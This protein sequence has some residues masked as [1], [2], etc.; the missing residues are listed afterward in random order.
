M[1]EL[2]IWTFLTAYSL[3]PEK[4]KLHDEEKK[5]LTFEHFGFFFEVWG[6]FAYNCFVC[7][8]ISLWEPLHTLIHL[9]LPSSWVSLWSC[10]FRNNSSV[11][12][13]KQNKEKAA[14]FLSILLLCCTM[15]CHERMK[16]RQTRKWQYRWQN[17]FSLYFWGENTAESLIIIGRM[18]DLLKTLLSTQD[19]PLPVCYIFCTVEVWTKL[20]RPII[21]KVW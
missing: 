21:A 1:E 18:S 5:S 12:C 10:N 11:S 13:E 17:Y 16:M 19:S 7:S 14:V 6:F 20:V 4:K 15:S 2:K 9:P 3:L 8:S